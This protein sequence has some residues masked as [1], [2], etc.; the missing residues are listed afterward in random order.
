MDTRVLRSRAQEGR[1]GRDGG[2]A[3][4]K[5]GQHHITGRTET[6]HGGIIRRRMAALYGVRT[7]GN[8]GDPGER[9]GLGPRPT[10]GVHAIQGNHM[11][12]ID[13]LRPPMR[14]GAFWDYLWICI[15]DI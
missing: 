3:G 11:Q 5:R 13:G 9:P 6:T 14:I 2:H 15:T 12:A 4:Q 7:Q 1:R 10:M 8:D